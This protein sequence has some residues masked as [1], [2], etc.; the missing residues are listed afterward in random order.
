MEK[1]TKKISNIEK[2]LS[3][4]QKEIIIIK[5]TTNNTN[6]TNSLNVS[7]NFANKNNLSIK[8]NREALHKAKNFFKLSKNYFQL[9]EKEKFFP[10]EKR[11]V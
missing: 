10:K 6:A 11:L 7:K 2:V 5:N 1:I 3:E 8:T 9:T 4:M